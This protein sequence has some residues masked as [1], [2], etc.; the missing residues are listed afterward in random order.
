[1]KQTLHNIC[2]LL[3]KT[4]GGK[5]RSINR[6]QAMRAGLIP[7]I[8]QVMQFSREL[9]NISSGSRHITRIIGR[10]RT[11]KIFFCFFFYLSGVII[12]ESVRKMAIFVTMVQNVKLYFMHATE[13]LQALHAKN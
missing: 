6:S 4:E 8:S 9:E 7:N 11:R 13:R 10:K 3:V 1:M 5:V 2:S 12:F